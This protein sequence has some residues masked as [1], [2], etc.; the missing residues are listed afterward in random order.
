MGKKS[1]IFY[2]FSN[3]C[4]PYRWRKFFFYFFWAFYIDK[5]QILQ[6]EKILLQF[7]GFY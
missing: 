3:L 1:H 7:S 6:I 4:Y 2:L 5:L